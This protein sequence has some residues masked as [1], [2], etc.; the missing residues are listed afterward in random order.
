MAGDFV[1]YVFL[2]EACPGCIV[3]GGGVLYYREDLDCTI[4]GADVVGE[5]EGG[6][7]WEAYDLHEVCQ[8]DYAEDYARV[9]DDLLGIVALE[10][11][12]LGLVAVLGFDAAVEAVGG[13]DVEQHGS[14]GDNDERKRWC[15]VAPEHAN[16][17]A[18]GFEVNGRCVHLCVVLEGVVCIYVNYMVQMYGK[19]VATNGQGSR[20]A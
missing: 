10:T 8:D 18:E 17:G 19:R 12:V 2:C 20:G 15:N 3:A 16:E 1:G 9:G 4:G 6:E 7:V 13:V 14:A 11:T 5:V